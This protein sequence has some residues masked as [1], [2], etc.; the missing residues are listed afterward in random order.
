MA[1]PLVRGSLHKYTTGYGYG[2]W[3]TGPP[4]GFVPFTWVSPRTEDADDVGK[5]TSRRPKRLDSSRRAEA[6]RTQLVSGEIGEWLLGEKL[7]PSQ[8]VRKVRTS[9][10]EE[11][12]LGTRRQHRRPNWQQQPR[13][14]LGE[15][16]IDPPIPDLVRPPQTQLSL[17]HGRLDPTLARAHHRQDLMLHQHPEKF[18]KRLPFGADV[19]PHAAFA[20]NELSASLTTHWT[21]SLRGQKW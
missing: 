11:V 17:E 1:D 10:L 3:R 18:K 9:T 19:N 16:P 12:D 13:A 5:S 21:H 2:T 6:A 20:Q 4:E 7:S 14:L 8:P 15:S